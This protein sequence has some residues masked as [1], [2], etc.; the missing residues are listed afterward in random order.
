MSTNHGRRIYMVSKVGEQPIGGE[1]TGS[2]DVASLRQFDHKR[3]NTVAG[4]TVALFSIPFLSELGV[5]V[6]TGRLGSGGTAAA[7]VSEA[8]VQ[9]DAIVRNLWL[10]RLAYPVLIIAL[11][12]ELFEALKD[13]A[14]TKEELGRRMTPPLQGNGRAL[15]AMI[16]VLS[17]LGLVTIQR[18]SFIAVSDA[19]RCV[20][21]R[22]S[23]YFWGAQLLASDGITSTLRRALHTD[24]SR[25]PQDYAGHSTASIDSFIDS[26]QAH[27]A[28]TAQATA[29]AL[30]SVIGRSSQFPAK[31]ILDM[32]GGS[33]CFAT[34]LSDR[35]G[36]KVTLA[37]LPAV[38]AKW[39]H[40]HP[41]STKIEAVPVDLFIAET[42][43]KN[44]P[45][46]H[47]MAN[48]LHDWG[49]PQVDSILSASCSA[50]QHNQVSS[51]VSGDT[52]FV[53]RL[54]MIE[55]LLADDHSGP[56]PAA[57]ASVSMLL[58]DWRTG[59]QY[60]LAELATLTRKAGFSRVELGPQCGPF[61]T[62]VV[63]YV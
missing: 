37:D 20:L 17:S 21:L 7:E 45:D 24:G 4:T 55:Q 35:Y 27:S 25:P 60:S 31:H 58:G 1:D 11:E 44:S 28:V 62:A 2:I 6:P 22:N 46:C 49:E 32:A 15:E 8:L 3:R 34:A 50:L 23:P 40:Q 57:L 14:L 33:G 53:G 19:A 61:H 47:L 42:W 43:P 13:T 54:I 29:V 36:V 18:N 10:N 38:V 52:N 56:L 26:M 30:D 48:V 51:P 16:A 41:F 12:M 5:S 59:K 63:A 39:R 9:G